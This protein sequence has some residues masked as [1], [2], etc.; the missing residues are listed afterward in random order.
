MRYLR[1]LYYLLIFSNFLIAGAAVAQCLLT[2]LILGEIANPYIL[3]IEGCST[4]LLYNFSLYLSKPAHPE[5]SPY[6]RTRWV[7]GHMSWFWSCSIVV[8]MTMGYALFHVHIWTLAYLV[9]VGVLSISYSFPFFKVNG[10]RVGLRQVPGVKLFYIA[11]VW[12]LSSVG[13]PVLE[14]WAEGLQVNWWVANYLGLLKILFLLI[15]TLPFDIRDMEQ[16]SYYHL[17]TIPHMIGEHRAKLVCYG[18]V[19]LHTVLVLFSPY[20]TAVKLGL[21]LTNVSIFGVLYFVIFRR[22]HSYHQVYLLDLALIWQYVVAYVILLCQC[23]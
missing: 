18:M 3:L 6:R 2:Y 13:L 20:D 5:R 14:L 10:K 12:S 23:P 4:L 9:F 17:R 21:V 22:I 16:D 8:L 19:L 1:Q 11:L 7:F 15:C